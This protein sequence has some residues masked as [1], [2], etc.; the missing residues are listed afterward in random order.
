MGKVFV[1]TVITV[2]G[3]TD[4]MNEWMEM[5]PHSSL[6]KTWIDQIHEADALLIGRKNYEGFA[7]V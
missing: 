6:W 3:V 1:S 2:D 4:Q 7:A 5:D